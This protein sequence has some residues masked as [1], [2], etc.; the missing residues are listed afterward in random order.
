MAKALPKIA[1]IENGNV[2]VVTFCSCNK[3]AVT[4]IATANTNSDFTYRITLI[5]LKILFIIIGQNSCLMKPPT[6]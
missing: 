6:L 3:K 2:M 4:A 5:G 1:D